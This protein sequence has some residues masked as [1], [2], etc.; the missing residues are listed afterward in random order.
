LKETKSVLTKQLDDLK[1][2]NEI[3][4][5]KKTL[6]SKRNTFYV[7]HSEQGGFFVHTP[8]AVENRLGSYMSQSDDAWVTSMHEL[9]AVNHLRTLSMGHFS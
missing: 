1:L 8:P 7:F 5:Q 4:E 9:L 3:L 2:N 6:M